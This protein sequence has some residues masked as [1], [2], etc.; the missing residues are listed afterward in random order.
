MF[1]RKLKKQVKDLY[2]MLVFIDKRLTILEKRIKQL[3]KG[4]ISEVSCDKV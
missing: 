4:E 3:E 1:N 2:L